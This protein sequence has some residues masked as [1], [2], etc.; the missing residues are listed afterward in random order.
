MS[1]LNL[2]IFIVF[3]LFLIINTSDS[4]GLEI[5]RAKSHED[6]TE[7]LTPLVISLSSEDKNE[8]VRGVDLICII[9]VSGSMYDNNK[10]TL[11]KESL[12]ILVKMM[13]ENDNIAL[14]QFSSSAK[15]IQPFINMTIENKKYIIDK[16]EN[17]E[18]SEGTNILEGLNKGLELLTKD[19][20]DGDRVASMI[21]LSDG[22]DL[23]ESSRSTVKEFKKTIIK[24]GKDNYIFTLHSFGYSQ[25]HDP[26]LMNQISKIRDGGYF[27]IKELFIVQDILLKIYGTLSTTFKVNVQLKIE[28]KINYPIVR[29]Y[30]NDEMYNSKFNGNN[31]FST[32]IIHFKYGKKYHFIALI[33][34]PPDTKNNTEILTVYVS[35]NDHSINL[36]KTYYWSNYFNSFAY[37]EYIRGISV[38]YFQKSYDS[39]EYNGIAIINKGIKWINENYDGPT[40]W[41]QRYID[42]RA[43]LE[44]FRSYGKASLLSKI[45]ELKTEKQ[46]IHYKDD[47]SYERSIIDNSHN[48]INDKIISSTI[49]KEE[50]ILEF[51]EG[52]NYVHFYL[53]EGIGEIN[54]ILFYEGKSSISIYS[55]SKESIK[56]KPISSS[57]EYYYWFENT[58]RIQTEVDF[59]K[60]G[61]FIFKKKNFPFHFYTSIDG[62]KDITFNIQFTKMDIKK[63][64]DSRNNINELLELKAYIL[65]ENTIK[66]F[67]N[68]ANDY[69]PNE[70]PFTGYYDEELRI[71]KIV[72]NKKEISKKLKSYYHNYLYISI[73]KSTK[74][75]TE[76]I[77]ENLEGQFTFVSMND[78]YSYIPEHFYIFSNL[79]VGQ[80]NPHLYK[81]KMEPAL[82][83]KMRIEFASSGTE[84]DCKVLKY[85]NYEIFS[86]ELYIDYSYKIER[87]EG[88]GKTY[89]DITQSDNEKDKFDSVILSIFSTNGGHMAGNE[90]RKLFY[91][92]RYSTYSNY[93]IYEYND[94]NNEKGKVIIQ[95]DIDTEK[96]RNL[97]ITFKKL[98]YKLINDSRTFEENSRFFL[99]V[100]H[101]EKKRQKIYNSISIFETKPV[102]TLE[103]YVDTQDASFEFTVNK[104]EK[105]FFTVYTIS[106]KNNE[107]ISYNNKYNKLYI[108]DTNIEIDDNKHYENEFNQDKNFE[109]FIKENIS[110]K[111]LVVKISN[112]DDGEYGFLYVH[113]KD[114]TY[115]SIHHSSQNIVVIPKEKC[116]GEKIKIEIKLK[117][118][119]KA[120]YIFNAQLSDQIEISVGEN[121]YFEMSEEYNKH[122]DVIITTNNEI[123][124][125]I[126]V[127][128]QSSYGDLIVYGDDIFFKKSRL[129][130]A[131]SANFELYKSKIITIKA[132]TGEFISFFTHIINNPVKINLRKIDINFYGFLE[133]KECIYIENNIE[134]D[135]KYQIRILGDKNISIIYDN[136]SIYEYTEPAI[137]YLNELNEKLKRICLKQS[138][139]YDSIFYNIQII[140]LSKKRNKNSYVFL[141]PILFDA[142]YSDKLSKGEFRY[143][144]Q[145]LF[146]PNKNSE[147]NYIYNAHQIKGEIKVYVTKCSDYSNCDFNKEYLEKDKETKI[148]YN[149]D[150]F[151]THSKKS[152]DYTSFHRNQL[153]YYV[154]LCLSD[155]CEYKFVLNKNTAVINLSKFG[156]YTS[157]ISKNQIDKFIISKKDNLEQISI[158]LSTHSGEVMLNANDKCEN[159][160]HMIFGHVEKIQIPKIEIDHPFE[161]YVQANMDSIYSIE[162]NEKNEISDTKYKKIKSN[163]VQL[164]I[165]N[166]EKIIEFEPV[167]SSYFIKFIPINCDISIKYGNDK[168]LPSKNK[169][170]YYSSEFENEKFYEF[171]VLTEKKECMIYTY[172]EEISDDY[173]AILSDKIPYYLSL[174]K[175]RKIYKFI[176][177][178]ANLNYYPMYRINFFEETPIKIINKINDEKDDEINAVLMK[179][180]KPSSNLLKTCD[181]EGICYLL[182]EI[183][184]EKEPQSPIMIEIILKSLNDI[185]GVLFHN[186]LKQDFTYI[187]G[188]QKYMAKIL[189]DEEGEINFNYKF[190][191]GELIGKLISIDKKTWKNRYELPEK[192]EQL[193]YDNLKQKI[194]FNKKETKD[195]INGCYLFV[196]VNSLDTFKEEKYYDGINMDYSIYLKISNNIVNLRFNEIIYGALS[197]SIEDSYIEYY[198][199][200]IPYSTNKIYI[201][202]SSENCIVIINSGVEKPVIE[203]HDYSFEGDQIYSISNKEQDYKGKIFTIGIYSKKL[204]N[205]ISKYNIRFRAE[206]KLFSNYI[207]SDVNI[208]NI[209]EIKDKNNTSCY[210]LIPIINVQKNSNLLLF[211]VSEKNSDNLIISYKKINL[212][213]ESNND[214]FEKTSKNQVIKNMLIIGKDELKMTENENILIK[215]DSNDIGKI[216][217][218]Y[219]FKSNLYESLIN[220]KNKVIYYM[221]PN[222]ELFL[223]LPDGLKG[224]VKINVISGKGT[225]GYENDKNSMKEISGQYSSIYLENNENK[226]KKRIK[227]TTDAEN[228]LYFYTDILLNKNVNDKSNNNFLSN[229]STRLIL[230]I[231][232]GIIIFIIFIIIICCCIRKRSYKDNLRQQVNNISFANDY[233]NAPFI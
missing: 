86:E 230:I 182:I 218:L 78:I 212:E 202:F 223:D 205:G 119:E 107:I 64:S 139:N 100:Y 144:Y 97:T 77:Y 128:V 227:I 127:F 145:G 123:K 213:K 54:G 137:L 147:L 219:T 113:I 231:I 108:S 179:D 52:K 207:Y 178:L 232:G 115:K 217:L 194:V 197:K 40:P 189:K 36:S 124:K 32:T 168:I 85:Q 24:S 167:K 162:Y 201:D 126:N 38:D 87:F 14:V 130:G 71:G 104:N 210:F 186:Q 177:P 125:N 25:D 215:I 10:M 172:I 173:Y 102:I 84:L 211:G 151:Y 114:K 61:K 120:E 187:K 35:T 44:N 136:N 98:Q 129:F 203:K 208:E 152:T 72:I 53:K 184:Y 170:Y 56:I 8:K 20:S 13:N 225:I 89:I 67:K 5:N 29:I 59:N 229:S 143:Y 206:H 226:G 188:N 83:K 140:N 163:I 65:A 93:G 43:D 174:N 222:E 183:K 103:K 198:S 220:P 142:Y 94:L 109:I 82:G 81:L 39:G 118:N 135:E 95:R 200:E 171:T 224:F 111:L 4:L 50:T 199:I 190:F 60:G 33:N 92:I 62:T 193:K 117:K 141:Q 181:K 185:P 90:N 1:K 131:Q 30:G 37:E 191:S 11:V 176:Y 69:E 57:L 175:N 110:K 195:C 73:I 16:I 160:T 68:K 153:L 41:P 209:C 42:V 76:L 28:S 31:T 63:K 21:L 180:I 26:I 112:F 45:S 96:G 46:G 91:T 9:D 27:F 47:N 165:I 121:L 23:Y 156:K 101:V 19:Y 22:Y 146:D 148:L 233:R 70:T 161:F 88:M 34:I 154:I 164:V 155:T 99:K 66:D 138:Y 48:I 132:E 55:D 133:Q 159:I 157:K 196:E 192:N 221:N 150:E 158:T 7:N 58:I 79:T 166:K 149:I 15:I 12:K 17:L 204:I 169:V 51:E 214:I 49:I 6:Q 3:Q 106:E 2:G 122:V 216:T 18:A 80:K 75:E 134:K 228:R 116:I 74:V 105:Y